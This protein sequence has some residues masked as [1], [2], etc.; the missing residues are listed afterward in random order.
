MR[1]NSYVMTTLNFS[2]EN[3]FL[4]N[5]TITNN[6]SLINLNTKAFKLLCNPRI[7]GTGLNFLKVS[8]IETQRYQTN[9]DIEIICAILDQREIILAQRNRK[10]GQ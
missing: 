1:A 4:L 6:T 3:S 9:S 7:L 5:I 8:H 10:S 2:T